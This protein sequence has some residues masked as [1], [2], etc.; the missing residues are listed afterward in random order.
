MEELG[1]QFSKFVYKEVLSCPFVKGA[2]EFLNQYYQKIPL[3]I[4]SG[5]PHEEMKLLIKER[6][7]S[8]YFKEVYGAPPGKGVLISKILRDYRFCPWDVLFVGDSVDDY[9][10]AKEAGV[11]FIGRLPWGEKNV[12]A[13][14]D[15]SPIVHDIF[16]LERVINGQKI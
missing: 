7:L 11:K 4:V 1:E 10:G 8:Q 9:K 2:Y 16:E 6:N 12:F 15:V 5:T 13:G 3:F 14:L